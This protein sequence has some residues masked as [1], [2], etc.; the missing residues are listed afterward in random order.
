MKDVSPQDVARRLRAVMHTQDLPLVQDLALFLG[1]RRSRVSAWLNGYNLPRVEEMATLIS[2]VPGLTLDWIYLGNADAVP[3]KFA[4]RLQAALDGMD[5][6]ADVARPA[7]RA[8][9][10]ALADSEIHR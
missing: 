9:A 4:I 10:A 7:G 3:L 6:P 1:V 5:C 2:L 8:R